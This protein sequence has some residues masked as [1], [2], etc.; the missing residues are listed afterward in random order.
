M[1]DINTFTLHYGIYIT[2]IKEVF[3]DFLAFFK[4][5]LGPCDES[6]Q[7]DFLVVLG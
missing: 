1:E 7:E 5:L 4:T 2:A 6:N 3:N